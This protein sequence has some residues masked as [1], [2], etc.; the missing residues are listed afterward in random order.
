MDDDRLME[1]A[2]RAARQAGQLAMS[3]MGNPGY[4]KRNGPHKIEIGAV[5]DVQQAIVKVIRGEFPDHAFLLAETDDLL[6]FDF[7]N[8]P[9]LWI[10]N[11]IAGTMN[12]YQGIP[13]FAISIAFREEGRYKLGV[14]YNPCQDELFQA[15]RRQGAKL[16]GQTINVQQISDGVEAY[17]RAVVG[18][19]VPNDME[20]SIETFK[21]TS[22]L[23]QQVLSLS[24][25]GSPALALCYLAAGRLHGYYHLELNLWDLAAAH[26]ILTEAGG[27]FTDAVGASWL[28]SDGGYVASN[29]IIH[30]R[31]VRTVQ[32]VLNMRTPTI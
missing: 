16:N 26:V 28:H 29:N 7:D 17:D 4:Q 21:I 15:M 5:R 20:R 2:I 8:P 22:V 9:N 6:A 32:S 24:I 11:A 14:V 25:L 10:I 18:T 19:D 12:F 3:R 31:L 1:T 13:F 23:A 30:G 27:I